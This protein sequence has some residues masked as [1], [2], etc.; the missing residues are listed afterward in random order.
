[1]FPK[2]RKEWIEKLLSFDTTSRNSNLSI[3][4]FL[5]KYLDSLNVETTLVY[6]QPKTKANMF[7]TF[8]A[9]DG[10]DKG[11]IIL[12]GHLDTVP[13]EGQKWDTDPFKATEKDG[14]IYGRGSCDMKGF[15]AQC[16][17]LA[18][19][20]VKM[21]KRKPIHFAWTYDEEIGCL[22]GRVLTAFLKA[23]KV[24]ADG[25]II[26]EPTSN[27]IVVAHKGIHVYQVTI[28]GKTCHS[29]MALTPKGCNAIDYA[30]KLIVKIREIAESLSVGEQDTLF[31]VPFTTMSTN[32]IHGG[33][34]LNIVPGECHFTYEFRNLPTA[35]K[36]TIQEKI[37]T[38]VDET[39]LPTMQK[40]YSDAQIKFNNTASVPGLPEVEDSDPFLTMVRTL[41]TDYSKK[42]V[43]FAAEGGQYAGIGIPT[44]LYGPG[45]IYVAHQANE[46]VHI[47]ELDACEAFLL[48]VIK[49]NQDLP[50]KI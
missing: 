20:F 22:G 35:A 44:V 29:A 25:C 50:S 14:K 28:I 8:R 30:A 7:V 23:N 40:E 19:V 1:M 5:K 32:I 9:A 18:P 37:Q 46:F 39:L 26:G 4:E 33:T 38:Y 21:A 43:A 10:Y 15:I 36:E 2:T 17:Y 31:D 45:S 13:V 42:K 41:H 11:G 12:S 27:K 49:R 47:D 6:N 16:M 34:A 48:N 3:V 24:T